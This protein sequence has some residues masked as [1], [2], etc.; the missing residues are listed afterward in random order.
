MTTPPRATVRVTRQFK[1]SPERVFDAWLRPDAV[2]VWML[3]ASEQVVRVEVE[4]RVGGR[5]NFVVLRQGEEVE[6][7][8]EYLELARPHRLAFT[9]G[10]PRYSKELTRVSID[11]EPSGTGTRLTLTHEGVFEDFISRTEAGWGR[12]LDAMAPT[13][14]G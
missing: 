4:A 13:F 11:L 1:A 2:R 3:P 7:V 14:G 6:H 9:W 12:I 8:G 10:A 5:F